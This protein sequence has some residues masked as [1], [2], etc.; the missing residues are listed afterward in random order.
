MEKLLLVLAPHTDDG[1][2]GCGGTVTKLIDQGYRAVSVAF[3]AA[4]ESVP[5]GFPKDILRKE[6]VQATSKLGILP[7]D[8]LTLHFSVRKF[9]EMRQEILEEMVRLNR[10]YQ[11]D[12]VFLPS[13]RD[14]H[15]DHLTIAQEGFRAFKKTNMLAY[16]APWNHLEFQNTCF[17]VLSDKQLDRKIEALSCYESQ[18][19]R[20]YVTAEFVK[21]LATVRG[22]QINQRYA[23]VFEAVRMIWKGDNRL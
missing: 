21:S 12:L 20:S 6:V 10:E 4:E 16:E 17:Q 7:A 11:P 19:H 5:A 3:S 14:T 22:A 9:P 15:Q 23:E 18:K 13:I 8:C 2:L 1:E